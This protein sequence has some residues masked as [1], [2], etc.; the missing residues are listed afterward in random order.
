MA[1]ERRLVCS[2][3]VVNADDWRDGPEGLQEYCWEKLR[4]R[5]GHE[6]RLG[7]WELLEKPQETVR[8]IEE[9][10]K[11]RLDIRARGQRERPARAPGEFWSP[12]FPPPIHLKPHRKNDKHGSEG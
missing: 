12:S 6:V 4:R 2:V 10:G 11:V 1:I 9:R 5:W 7:H 3:D 8:F